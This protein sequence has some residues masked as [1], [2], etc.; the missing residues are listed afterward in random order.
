MVGRI[1]M[2]ALLVLVTASSA[3]AQV[4]PAA[5]RVRGEVEE[6]VRGSG[7]GEALESL[8]A[9]AAPEL[10]RTL[11]DLAG[12][13]EAL[14]RRI[15]EDRELRASAVQAGQGMVAVVEGVLERHPNLLRDALREAAE[16]IGELTE[17]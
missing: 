5:E 7:V 1:G 3:A 8:A 2:L 17:P 6:V 11:A 10:Q 12:S 15:A 16:R 4:A 9:A 14:A 13:I